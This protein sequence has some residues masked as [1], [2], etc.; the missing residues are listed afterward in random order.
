METIQQMTTL[1]SMTDFVTK[2]VETGCAVE[3]IRRLRAYSEFLR[4]PLSLGQFVPTSEAGEVL[5]YPD[6][7]DIK[8]D[9]PISDFE[10]DFD[11]QAYDRDVEIY[12][13]ARKRVLFEGFEVTE[14]DNVDHYHEKEIKC[15]NVCIAGYY[16]SKWHLLSGQ[17]TIEDLVPFGLTLTPTAKELIYK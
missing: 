13:K 4:T 10:V 2:S 5:E 9:Y 14:Y 16:N 12:E 6:Q 8:Y 3:Q 11:Y 1:C 17:K 7:N 15:G